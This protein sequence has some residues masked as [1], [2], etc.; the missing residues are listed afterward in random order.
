MADGDPVEIDIPARRLH[1]AVDGAV[2]GKCLR[3][4]RRTHGE[5]WQPETRE[6]PISDTLRLYS[7]SVASASQGAVRDLDFLAPASQAPRG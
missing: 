2:L 3:E 1:L 7:R 6:R 5:F 4:K